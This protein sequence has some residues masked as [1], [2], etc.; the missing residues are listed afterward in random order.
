MIKSSVD[1]QVKGLKTLKKKLFTCI[2]VMTLMLALSACGGESSDSVSN[3]STSTI[4]SDTPDTATN[5]TSETLPDSSDSSA[6]SSEQIVVPE[7]QPDVIGLYIPSDDGT[8]SRTLV[9]EFSSARTAGQDIDCFEAI[10]SNDSLLSGSSFAEIWN[11]AWDEHMPSAAARI[12]YHI[13]I[14]LSGGDT[15]SKTLLKPSDSDEFFDYVEIYMYD[16]I[17]QTPGAWYTHLSDSDMNEE[18]IISSIKLTAGQN[19]SS[20][21]DIT[22]TAFVYD[23]DSNFDSDGNY[24]GVVTY[25]I[26]ITNA[27]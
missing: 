1:F 22:L 27:D 11:A 19:I 9:S 16:D 12:G 3:S 4:S 7:I 6:D 13:T 26:E 2:C 24:V 8:G 17:N 18:T 23:D 25:S 10:A 20:V 21:G 15:I 14:E 5:D